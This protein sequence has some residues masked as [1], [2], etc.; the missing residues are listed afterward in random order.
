M[1]VITLLALFLLDLLN[2][3]VISHI[4]DDIKNTKSTIEVKLFES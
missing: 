4:Q 3:A 1:Y 2:A